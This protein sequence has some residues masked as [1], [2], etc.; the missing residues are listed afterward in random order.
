MRCR[1]VDARAVATAFDKSDLMYLRD[2][3]ERQRFTEDE[4]RDRELQH[5]QRQR[6]RVEPAA[7]GPAP[8]QPVRRD[9]ERAGARCCQGPVSALERV[10]TSCLPRPVCP[11]PHM[12][13]RGKAQSS[14]LKVKGVN[15]AASCLSAHVQPRGHAGLSLTV[16]VRGARAVS[17]QRCCQS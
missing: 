1:S 17:R 5:F 4:L 2:E 3:E 14:A 8:P 11:P 6:A 16:L 12:L 10:H 13:R 7:P 15:V 9:K